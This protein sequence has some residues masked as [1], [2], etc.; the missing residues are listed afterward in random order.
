MWTVTAVDVETGMHHR[1][2]A[3]GDPLLSGS[4]CHPPPPRFPPVPPPDEAGGGGFRDLRVPF[5]LHKPI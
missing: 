1:M 2:N 3:P 5:H 4:R